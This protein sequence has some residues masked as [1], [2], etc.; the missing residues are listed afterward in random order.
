MA[1]DRHLNEINNLWREVMS[2]SWRKW[3]LKKWLLSN[4]QCSNGYQ[5]EENIRRRKCCGNVA[6]PASMASGVM[7]ANGGEVS[8]ARYQ[9]QRLAK[10][11]NQYRNMAY[12]LK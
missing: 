6:Q 4:C 1:A 7:S 3:R 2:V 9:Y 8:S 12:Q 5:C 11:I 10:S